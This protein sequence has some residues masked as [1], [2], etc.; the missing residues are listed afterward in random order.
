MEPTRNGDGTGD[1]PL[2]GTRPELGVDL[3]PVNFKEKSLEDFIPLIVSYTGKSVITKTQAPIS[4]KI[5]IQSERLVPK[6][7]ALNL[8]FQAFRLNGIGV[9]ETE[10]MIMIDSLTSELNN[11]QPGLILGP[12]V[13]VSQMDED[14][15]IV[16]KVFR[17]RHAKAAEVESQI[18]STRPTY[19]SVTSD[20][21]SNQIIREMDYLKNGYNF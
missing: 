3:V 10:D 6:H 2:T 17:L 16:T 20:V 1:D 7:E 5:S 21:N 14:G 19:A 15:Q 9:V 18:D 8:I 13:D 11:F 4:T 12:E